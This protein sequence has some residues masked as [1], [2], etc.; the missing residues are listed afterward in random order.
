M[1]EKGNGGGYTTVF[2]M[3]VG[4]QGASGRLGNIVRPS[5]SSYNTRSLGYRR[6]CTK[7]VFASLKLLW[8]W[9]LNGLRGSMCWAGIY[10]QDTRIYCRRGPYFFNFLPFE[11]DPLGFRVNCSALAYHDVFNLV[12]EM[13]G[14]A[15]SPSIGGIIENRI[16][17]KAFSVPPNALWSYIFTK[18]LSN[19]LSL[20]KHNNWSKLS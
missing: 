18:W 4:H 13:D 15:S 16:I 7:H 17:P 3:N 6:N 12:I 20:K 5:S 2:E 14:S 19:F 9:L 8:W 10:L 1:F 11:N